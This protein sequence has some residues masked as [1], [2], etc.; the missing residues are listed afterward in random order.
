M[1]VIITTA[2]CS[3]KYAKIQI[4]YVNFILIIEISKILSSYDLPLIFKLFLFAVEKDSTKYFA[5][6]TQTHLQVLLTL[7]KTT[8]LQS[9]IFHVTQPSFILPCSSST[10]FFFPLA[11]WIL[12]LRIKWRKLS[13]FKYYFKHF[14]CSH[15]TEFQ[16]SC[17]PFV[18]QAIWNENRTSDLY[19]VIKCFKKSNAHKK[20]K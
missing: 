13:L 3:V 14:P 2:S 1:K 10:F 15:S 20:I 11:K 16:Q 17:L 7:P 6:T 9:L 12:S 5:Y 18:T 4:L 8:R 19:E